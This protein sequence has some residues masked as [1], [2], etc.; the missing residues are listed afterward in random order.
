MIPSVVQSL[1]T[2]NRNSTGKLKI[3]MNE[4]EEVPQLALIKKS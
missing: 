3:E 4:K 2:M 1:K